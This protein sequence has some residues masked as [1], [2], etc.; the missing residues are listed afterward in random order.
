MGGAPSMHVKKE[1]QDTRAIE[2]QHPEVKPAVDYG[3]PTEGC[4]SSKT[5]RSAGQPGIPTG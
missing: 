3:K 5:S 1:K 4:S 2:S